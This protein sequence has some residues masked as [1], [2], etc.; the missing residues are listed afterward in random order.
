MNKKKESIHLLTIFLLLTICSCGQTSTTK[1]IDGLVI[2]P[3]VKIDAER[4]IKD[5]K[6]FE[7][8]SQGFQ[9]YENMVT[10]ELYENDSLILSTKDNPKNIVFKSF[11]FWRG[12]T[13]FIDGGIGLFGGGGFSIQIINDKATVYH[14]LSSDEFPT[15][16]YEEKSKLIDRLEVPCRDRKVILSEVP[17]QGN[18]KVIYGYVEFKSDNYFT[19]QGTVD[20]K[21]FR[22]RKKSRANM[23]M[24][25]KSGEVKL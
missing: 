10:M 3:K 14:M 23:K 9:I 20:G 11:Y 19:S 17:K 4:N 22:P 18:N 5:S 12:D 15:Y 16:A 6:D 24:Y 25:F 2:N 21:E 1:T 8:I 13:L 7:K